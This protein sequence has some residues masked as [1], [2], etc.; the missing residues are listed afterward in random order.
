MQKYGCILASIG[1]FINVHAAENQITAP[2]LIEQEVIQ[3]ITDIA[4]APRKEWSVQISHYENEEG[5]VTSSIERYTPNEDTSKQWTLLR[6]NDKTPSHKQIK[7]F[8]KKK[9]EHV[10][11]KANGKIY[12][13]NFKTLIEQD[14]LQ[15]LNHYGSHAKVGFQVHLEDLGDDAKGKLEGTLSYSKQHK[16]IEEITIVNNAEF[17]PMFSATISDLVLSFNFIKLNDVVLPQQIEMRM[18]G[19]F[20]YFTEIDE[21]STTTYS[22]YLHTR[23]LLSE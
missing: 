13:I 1:C 21:V 22:N 10:E 6:I 8:V 12:S 14:S 5:D 16:Y 11:N 15:L 18:K 17:S 7:K 19:S 9:Q 20:A 4:G 23:K 2:T 3:A